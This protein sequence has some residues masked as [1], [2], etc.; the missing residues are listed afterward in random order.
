MNHPADDAL[1]PEPGGPPPGEPALGG[2]WLEARIPAVFAAVLATW[3][4]IAGW[5]VL[6][7]L[8]G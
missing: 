3:L 8:G 2:A 4:L 6:R 7:Q 5:K 1:S